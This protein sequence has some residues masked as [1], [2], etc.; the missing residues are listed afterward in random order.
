M[1]VYNAERYLAVAI[2]SIL[3]QTFRDFEFLIVDDGSTDRSPDI[4]RSYAAPMI[5]FACGT[6]RIEDIIQRHN[7]ALDRCRGTYVAVMDA[8]DVALPFR[9]ERQTEYLSVHPECV[10]LGSRV[11]I[12][13]PDGDPLR[14]DFLHQTH[15]NID[16]AHIR[17]LGSGLCHPA[18]MMR[19]QAVLDVGKYATDLRGALDLDLF[20]RLVEAGGRVANL[21][22]ILLRYRAHHSSISYAEKDVQFENA[23]QILL[24][25][26]RRRGLADDHGVIP[27]RHT[28]APRVETHVKWGWW[29]LGSG[30]VT[31][32]RK[33]ARICL[34][35]APFSRTCWQLFLCSLRGY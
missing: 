28:I 16:D 20:L 15:E 7:D 26:R 21:P 3:I 30:H 14:E 25:A 33:H 22:E 18:V 4:L 2:E 10:V 17:G 1:S 32:A 23:R 19:R 9:F 24:R 12:I 11:Q 29:A 5:G 6:C 13:D 31:T 8:D 27:P 34:R 35:Q